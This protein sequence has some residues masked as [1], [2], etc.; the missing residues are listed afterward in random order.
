MKQLWSSIKSVINIRQSSNISVISKLKDTDGNIS[1]DPVVVA[2][3]FNE[4]FVNV[5]YN[6]TKTI[7]RSN[8]APVNFMGDK[9]R[10]SF[11]TAPSVPHE[12]S[13]IIC[14]C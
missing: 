3:I 6:I 5:S 14:W 4:F 11:F 10:N 1:S 12:I 2:N 13:E 7:P 8:N 9:I